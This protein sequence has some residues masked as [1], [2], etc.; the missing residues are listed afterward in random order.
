[1]KERLIFPDFS[2]READFLA[3]NVRR[4]A[5]VYGEEIESIRS[6]QEAPTFDNTIL[7]LEQAGEDFSI[8]TSIFFNL[9]SCDA[10]DRMMELSQE[11]T[12]LLTDLS[13][14]IGMDLTIAKRVKEVYDN[15][16]QG[17]KGAGSLDDRLTY[18]TY[19]S[20]ERKGAFLDD[21]TREQLKKLRKE[22]SLATLNFGQN[23]LREQNAYTLQVVDYECIKR[24]PLSALESA[25]ELAEEQS[26]EGWLFDL[27]M[28][29]YSAILKFCDDRGVREQMYRA[30]VSL[31]MDPEQETYNIDL[32]YKIAELRYEIAK[33]LGY[34]TY[35]EYVLSA[36]MAKM[37]QTVLDML[38]QLKVAYYPLAL[39]EI[40]QVTEGYKE[41]QAW[42]WSY[43][44]EIYRQKHLHYDEE[45]TRPYFQLESVVGAMFDLACELYELE[46]EENQELKAYRE[47]V[48]VYTVTSHG[49]L[50]GTLLCD[51]F[52]RKGKRSGAW[53]TNF[54]DAY[55]EVRPVVSL[56]M[57][58]TPPTASQPSLLTH[59]E[60]TTLFHEFGHGLHGL[61]TK[62]PYAS[63]SGT[64]VVHDF[65][66]LPSHFNENWSRNPEFLRSF[67]K[68]YETG[69]P[70]S[71]DLLS[72]IQ[73]NN[74]FLEG[75]GCIRQLGFG[76]LD[77]YWH[78]NDPS[79]LPVDIEIL[80]SQAR[81]GLEM[82]PHVPG[83]SISSAFSH[84]FSG[85][86]ASGYYG[87]KWSEILEADAF[88]EFLEHGITDH[89][90]S[91]RFKQEI[92]ERGD[93]DEPEV[94]YQNFKGRSATISALLKRSGLK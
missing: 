47:D 42:D 76:Y 81:K 2:N 16:Y 64:N 85:G 49:E 36:K 8:A 11:L 7:A 58:F 6:N 74:L 57:N 90:T 94:L 59:D 45:E 50:I 31:C 40:A 53:M 46:I 25:K 65:V 56:V 44:A 10:D 60:V 4:Q 39:Q 3:Q 9:L 84:I 5:D 1:M 28:P 41:F 14:E 30:K 15:T 55:R 22:L 79:S 91:M 33:L 24:L 62:I 54:I 37:P 20:Y 88:E 29:A 70:I 43:L 86:Y 87:Y 66:E 67:A 89:N 17:D 78:N 26:R 34:N 27:S 80:E 75:Y 93:A 77:M 63:L 48:K 71:E 35:A 82:L 12:P 52:P 19:Q 83:T 32:V 68:H 38:D 92:L 18:R 61:L 21:E 72:A 23:I 73:R 13:N 69:D 51:F